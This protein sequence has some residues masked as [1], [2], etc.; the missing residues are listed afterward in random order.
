MLEHNFNILDNFYCTDLW[1]E[2]TCHK[3][4]RYTYWV[5]RLEKIRLEETSWWAPT[6]THYG[7]RLGYATPGVYRP[8]A[9]ECKSCGDHSTKIFHE[10]WTCL[11]PTCEEFFKFPPEI[12]IDMGLTYSNTML[13]ERTAYT[14]DSIPDV[15]PPLPTDDFTIVHPDDG[16]RSTTVS[17]VGLACPRCGCYSRRRDW[18]FWKCENEA[19]GL[20]H[21][22]NRRL[23]SAADT[24]EDEEIFNKRRFKRIDAESHEL[25]RDPCIHRE[26]LHIAGYDVLQYLFPEKDGNIIGS[27]TLYKATEQIRTQMNGPDDLYQDVQ[28]VNL[29]LKRRP[30]RHQGSKYPS[31]LIPYGNCQTCLRSLVKS[32]IL[33]RN[34]MHNYVGI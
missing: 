22:A 3:G 34:F 16:K 19:C 31:S 13:L 11:T 26:D 32:E 33:T 9:L 27:V 14:G 12:D 23:I 21:Y 7:S 25:F 8:S 29:P 18:L 1:A 24:R 30:T 6:D 4:Q 17:R 5:C 28:T 10:A 20:I 2:Q 15:M